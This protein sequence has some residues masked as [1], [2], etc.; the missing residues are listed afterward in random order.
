MS[1]NGDTNEENQMMN[2]L[3]KE[4]A[5]AYSIQISPTLM[6]LSRENMTMSE[7]QYRSLITDSKLFICYIN[8]NYLNSMQLTSEFT[9]ANRFS[10]TIFI[11][12]DTANVDIN[13]IELTNN[14]K[15]FNYNDEREKHHLRPHIELFLK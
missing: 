7:F 4:L 5:S 10:K 13:E 15:V 6:E 3:C 8:G 1:Y 2:F 12:L 9:L 11:L 14:C